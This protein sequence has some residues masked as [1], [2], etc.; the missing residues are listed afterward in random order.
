METALR[1]FV[2]LYLNTNKYIDNASLIKLNLKIRTQKRK[3]IAAPNTV[4]SILLQATSDNGVIISFRADAG[5]DG[6][7]RR[8]KPKDVARIEIKYC[9]GNSAPKTAD[10]CNFSLSSG[11]SPITLYVELSE[12]PKRIYIFARWVSYRNE[13]GNWCAMKSAVVA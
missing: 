7:S 5:T 13:P 8:G 1:Y 3:R 11:S 6:V 12:Q 9:I 2:R 4:P 10:D